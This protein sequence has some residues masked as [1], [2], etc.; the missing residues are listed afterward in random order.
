MVSIT[1]YGLSL[2]GL[3]SS[4]GLFAKFFSGHPDLSFHHAGELTNYTVFGS[5]ISS[6][7]GPHI[8]QKHDLVTP[9]G[10]PSLAAFVV[11]SEILPA[12]ALL[13]FAPISTL[14][15]QFGVRHSMASLHSYVE[16]LSN[17]GLLLQTYISAFTA[18]GVTGYDPADQNLLEALTEVLNDVLNPEKELSQTQTEQLIQDLS[19]LKDSPAFADASERDI[20]DLR[21]AQDLLRI[22]TQDITGIA[23]DN[24]HWTEQPGAGNTLTVRIE[25]EHT[26]AETPQW[27]RIE[28]PH[29]DHLT[30]EPRGYV[31]D[32]P[33]LQSVTA[34]Q[35][36]M[37]P[38]LITH[39]LLRVDA[40]SNVAELT[41]RALPDN[42]REDNRLDLGQLKI[43]LPGRSES[44][45]TV[46]I[47]A[48]GIHEGVISAMPEPT[49]VSVVGDFEPVDFDPAQEGV[50][51]QY[52]GLG[53]IIVDFNKPAARAD[54]LLGSN[55]H[56][57]ISAGASADAVFAAG[58]DDHIELGEGDDY[59][60]GGA[61]L[62]RI[63][64]GT[65]TDILIGGAGDDQ[66]YASSSSDYAVALNSDET[67]SGSDRD[68]LAGGSPAMTCSWAA[69][70]RMAS[71]EAAALT[72]SL[73]VPAM[74]ISLATMTGSP[75]APLG[76]TPI[77]AT[78]FASL[79][80]R[81][82][83]TTRRT[84]RLTSFTPVAVMIMSG[85]GQEMMSCSEMTA[86]TT[87][88]VKPALIC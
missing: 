7:T 19:N 32:T 36:A 47:L 62:D 79:P 9:Q 8:G 26:L 34:N 31:I 25:L 51:E 57:H 2:A 17:S 53:N 4:D 49:V 78:G 35:G 21:K 45:T 61:G 18:H 1:R 75:R 12:E 66:L 65:G 22:A 74:I 88:S 86:P 3:Y 10:R 24:D 6:E 77:K 70:A 20:A 73:V 82:A 68:W 83:P 37:A 55:N 85:P 67:L 72:S 39:Y 87:C 40:G 60:E 69:R 42:D 48:L 64:G 38:P 54:T 43:S 50:Q 13:L 41:L 59:A 15:D 58:G 28:L 46:A 33:G 14:Y 52:D 81:T 5:A 56:D 84:R 76:V 23:L 29:T 27:I 11:E 30:G 63:E 16:G 80:R 71:P 44:P